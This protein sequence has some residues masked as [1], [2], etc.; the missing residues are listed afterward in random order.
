MDKWQVLCGCADPAGTFSIA[1]RQR[2]EMQHARVHLGKSRRQPSFSPGPQVSRGPL[3]SLISHPLHICTCVPTHKFTSKQLIKSFDCKQ[4]AAAKR[5]RPPPP[6]P[7]PTA[8]EL[9]QSKNKSNGMMPLYFPFVPQ[10]REWR[11]PTRKRLMMS[12][13]SVFLPSLR[14]CGS[15]LS[16]SCDMHELHRL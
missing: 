11:I 8:L 12:W 6:T 9:V 2:A 13:L 7:T 10:C 16:S 4:E 3:P 14:F 5:C 15:H 1:V